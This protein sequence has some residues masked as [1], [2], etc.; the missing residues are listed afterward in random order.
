MIGHMLFTLGPMLLAAAKFFSTRFFSITSDSSHNRNHRCNMEWFMVLNDTT[1]YYPHP[2]PSGAGHHHTSLPSFSRQITGRVRRPN[3]ARP[4][5]SD[6]DSARS[7]PVAHS[8]GVDRSVPPGI[9]VEQPTHA[10]RHGRV[11][12]RLCHRRCSQA[13]PAVSA[14]TGGGRRPGACPCRHSSPI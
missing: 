1:T 11:A 3:Q 9:G 12:S 4:A 13:E 14:T 5:I 10:R 2:G 7:Q 8:G 6:S